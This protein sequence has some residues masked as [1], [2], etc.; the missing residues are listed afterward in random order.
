MDADN[1]HSPVKDAPPPSTAAQD[2]TSAGEVDRQLTF[3]ATAAGIAVAAGAVPTLLLLL[4]VETRWTPLLELD[5]SA[6][7]TLHSTGSPTRASPRS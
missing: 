2:A 1:S 4:T 6:R 3:R 5:D 7:D